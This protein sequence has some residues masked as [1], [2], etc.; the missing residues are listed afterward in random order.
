MTSRFLKHPAQCKVQGTGHREEHQCFSK[1]RAESRGGSGGFNPLFSNG[2]GSIISY[3]FIRKEKISNAI[4]N[5]YQVNSLFQKFLDPALKVEHVLKEGRKGTAVCKQLRN[6]IQNG[7][8]HMHGSTFLSIYM[9]VCV[10][11]TLFVI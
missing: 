3:N 11:H 9:Y 4:N 10:V 2:R 8:T 5:C 6:K 1:V 7:C